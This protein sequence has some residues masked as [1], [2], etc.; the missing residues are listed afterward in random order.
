[1]LPG[2]CSKWHGIVRQGRKEANTRSVNCL[3]VYQKAKGANL[4]VR[5]T[6]SIATSCVAIL[7]WLCSKHGR[8]PELPDATRAI[9]EKT[10]FRTS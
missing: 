5:K 8:T 2:R 4:L 3:H 1:M 10:W 7:S 6:A 9:G